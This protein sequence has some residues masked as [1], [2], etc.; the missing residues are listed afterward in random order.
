LN[1]N[2]GGIMKQLKFSGLVAILCL[3]II[4]SI[5]MGISWAIKNT[6]KDSTVSS[7]V[8]I[9]IS[10]DNVKSDSL[11]GENDQQEA[12]FPGKTVTK[13]LSI[14]NH[15]GEAVEVQGIGLKIE[16]ERR[17]GQQYSPVTDEQLLKSYAQS[18]RIKLE[19]QE[20]TAYNVIYDGTFLGL[21]YDEGDLAYQGYPLPL[22]TRWK[23]GKGDYMDLRCTASMDLGA[24]NELQNLKAFIEFA[25]DI[26]AD[27]GSDKPSKK[28]HSNKMTFTDFTDIQG[29]WTHDCIQALLIHGIIQG[30]PDGTIKPDHFITRAEVA[31]LLANALNLQQQHG[32]SG[33]VDHIPEWANGYINAVTEHNVFQG[34]PGKIFGADKYITREEFCVV[35]VKAFHIEEDPQ[36]EFMFKDNGEISEW[37]LKYVRAA[38]SNKVVIGYEDG[39]FRPGNPITRA[40]VCTI[41]CK[42]LNY[43]SQHTGTPTWR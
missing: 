8:E 34:Y 21:L 18:M 15:Y 10:E 32:V 1:E 7:D 14:Y 29:H 13:K 3:M 37:A 26:G 20:G 4:F 33:Y 5:S 36:F 43:H 2:Q 6:Y 22:S 30:Y 16:L 40:E 19:K 39:T 41:L 42:L 27:T 35:V 25:I 9:Y 17:Y 23:I 11:F 28:N 24:G 31:I 38:A 12:W